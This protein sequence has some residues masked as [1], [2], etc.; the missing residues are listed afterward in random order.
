MVV[1]PE[2]RATPTRERP[3]ER[4]CGACSSLCDATVDRVSVAADLFQSQAKAGTATATI[5]T[6]IAI[7]RLIFASSDLP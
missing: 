4:P 5:S 7:K 3:Y 1:G 2:S 6:A